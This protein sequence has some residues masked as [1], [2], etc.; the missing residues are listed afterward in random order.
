MVLMSR[1]GSSRRLSL[2]NNVESIK[3][4]IRSLLIILSIYKLAA[5]LPIIRT[6]LSNIFSFL[7]RFNKLYLSLKKEVRL[8]ANDVI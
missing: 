7:S 6:L 1:I 5:L 3:I 2:V 8:D 4:Y